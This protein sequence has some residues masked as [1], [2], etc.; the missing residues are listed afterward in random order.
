MSEI[1]VTTLEELKKVGEGMVV[2]L[3]NFP[4]GT[5]LVVKI[6]YPSLLEMMQSDGSIPNPLMGSVLEIAPKE[7][8]SQLSASDSAHTVPTKE[9]VTASMELIRSLCK[10]CLVSPTY[11]EIEE[12]AGG[13]TDVQVMSLYKRIQGCFEGLGSFRAT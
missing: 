10:K 12:L 7:V 11:T 13:M 5:P 8:K 6:R 2:Q 9:Q 1:Y 4:N 3:P